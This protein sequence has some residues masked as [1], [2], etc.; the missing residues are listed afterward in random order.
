MATTVKYGCFILGCNE[1]GFMGAR[2]KFF[3]TVVICQG[4]D[5]IKHGYALPL[6]DARA[7][8]PSVH[9]KPKVAPGG[10]KV[11]A[12]TSPKMPPSNSGVA[13]VLAALRSGQ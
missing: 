13:Q 9:S 8:A 10:S 1:R 3:G 4:H 5:L 11:L 12:H 2:H 7:A 6:Y